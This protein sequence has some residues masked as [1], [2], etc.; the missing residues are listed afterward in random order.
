LRSGK[1]RKSQL[2]QLGEEATFK[3]MLKH[4]IG[5]TQLLVTVAAASIAFGG[6]NQNAQ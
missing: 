4:Y 6:N 5:V 3:P 1:S 2:S